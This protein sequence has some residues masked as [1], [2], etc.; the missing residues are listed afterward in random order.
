MIRGGT[1]ALKNENDR[2]YK[3]IVDEFQDIAR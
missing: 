2:P 1:A 3:L